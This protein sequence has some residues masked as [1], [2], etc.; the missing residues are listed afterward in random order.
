MYWWL[1]IIGVARFFFFFLLTLLNKL[2]KEKDGR[3]WHMHRLSS[4]SFSC[5]FRR[6]RKT[7]KLTTPMLLMTVF[8]YFG[9]AVNKQYFFVFSLF[10]LYHQCKQNSSGFF[11]R[12]PPTHMTNP[13]CTAPFRSCSRESLIPLCF[14]ELFQRPQSNRVFFSV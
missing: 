3:G 4:L 11:S 6:V 5:L 9:F 1:L 13:F 12:F 10:F 14:S 2:E 7:K 8:F